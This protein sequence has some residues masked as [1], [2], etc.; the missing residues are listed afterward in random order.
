[1]SSADSRSHGD[2]SP[3]P[4][5]LKLQLALSRAEADELKTQLQEVTAV[6][7]AEKDK[8]IQRFAKERQELLDSIKIEMANSFREQ[9]AQFIPLQHSQSTMA[10]GSDTI[11]STLSVQ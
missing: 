5:D 9:M 11:D 1:M 3:H 4:L 8:M 10:T 7:K 2:A 6:F